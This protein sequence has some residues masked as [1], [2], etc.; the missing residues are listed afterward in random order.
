MSRVSYELL[1]TFVITGGAPTFGA[2]A[3][4]LRLS[5]SAVSQQIRA[6]ESQLG[7]P[8]FVRIGRRAQLTEAGHALRETLRHELAIIDEAVETFSGAHTEV[9]GTITL[10]A[11][12]AFGRH[13]LRPRLAPLLARYPALRLRVE[14]GVPSLIERRLAEGGLDLALLPRPSELPSVSARPLATEEFW[15]L[16]APAYVAAHPFARTREGFAAQRFL[17][18]DGDLAMH[19]PWWRAHFGA[20]APGG[21]IVAEVADLDELL[22]LCEAGLGVVVLPDYLARASV[23]AGRTVRLEVERGLSPRP[24]PARNTIFLA[25][26]EGVIE[27]ARFLALREALQSPAPG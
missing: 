9:K 27:S 2:A 6:L 11:P 23:E 21:Q 17:V 4:A 15:A 25:W 10:G 16:A 26:R 5:V 3:R 12:R 18:F 8:L 22:A 20:S 1:R 24:R 19:A 7:Q 14:F 13:W